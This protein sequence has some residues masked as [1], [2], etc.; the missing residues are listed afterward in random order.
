MDGD[1]M[2]GRFKVTAS[3]DASGP[4]VSGLAEQAVRDWTEDVVRALANEGADMLRST[5][6]AK[7]GR[8]R[9]NFQ[10]NIQVL[11]KGPEATIPAPMIKGVT[12]GP[13]LE[14][15]SSR[16]RSTRFKGYHMFRKTRQEL[17]QK[18]PEIAEHELQKYLPR[19][20]GE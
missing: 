20:G 11:Q 19:M 15:T 6:M 1:L 4:L 13:W 8:A 17:E 9:G 2:G 12:W 14:G 16:N 7:S 10:R 3:L 5:I 18:A